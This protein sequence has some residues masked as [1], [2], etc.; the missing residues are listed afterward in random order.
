MER[1]S[2]KG[3]SDWQ[4]QFYSFINRHSVKEKKATVEQ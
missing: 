1:N 3:G 4:F 2:C